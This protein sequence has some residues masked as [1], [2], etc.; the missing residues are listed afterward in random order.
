M[1]L[2]LGCRL[3]PLLL[4]AAL[5]LTFLWS[6]AG[7]FRGETVVMG[8]D[9]AILA[10]LGL[11]QKPAETPAPATD[12]ARPAPKEPGAPPLAVL[13]EP[14]VTPSARFTPE[15]FREPM[16]TRRINGI[17][18]LVAKGSEPGIRADGTSKPRL[19]PGVLGKG[20]WPQTLAWAAG[21]TQVIGGGL[22]LVGLLTRVSALLNA[23]TMGVAIWLTQVGPAWQVGKTKWGLVPDL[24]P[25]ALDGSGYAPLLWLL[26]LLAG[27]LGVG[28]TGGGTLALD[29]IL[30]KGAAPT[31]RTA[32]PKPAA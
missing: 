21:L 20:H 25:L 22:L 2:P 17:A 14:G 6:G 7:R 30:L 28:L 26:L 31:P 27:A 3:S 9:A 12:P 10:N 13:A 19:V 11:I 29:N 16:S 18:L 5:G 4:R 15:D 32:P 24:D 23:F 8:A 1:G